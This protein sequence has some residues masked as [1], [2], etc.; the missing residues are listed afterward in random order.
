METYK[1]FI[2]RKSKDFEKE[3]LVKMRDISRKGKNYWIREDW[4]FLPQH[5]YK[6][7]VFIIERLKREKSIRKQKKGEIQYRVGYYIV[8]K[9]GRAK[10]K[11]V[12]GQFCPMIPQKDFKKL[13]EKA[14]KEKIIL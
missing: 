14:K 13:I 1:K 9:N 6:R 8:G 4:T 3:K 7:K 11:W 5:N 10:N 2:E 12:W